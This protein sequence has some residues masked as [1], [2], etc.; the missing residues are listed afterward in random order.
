MKNS[1]AERQ[2]GK[3]GGGILQ[4]AHR[5]PLDRRHTVKELKEAQAIH[6]AHVGLKGA[7]EYGTQ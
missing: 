4:N 3:S 5:T 1:S 7:T 6:A 2:Q